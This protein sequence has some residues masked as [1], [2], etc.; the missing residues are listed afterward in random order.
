[1]GSIA[2]NAIAVALATSV[3]VNVEFPIEIFIELL[4]VGGFGSTGCS[5]IGGPE[6]SWPKAPSCGL[7]DV[8]IKRDKIVIRSFKICKN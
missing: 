7:H 2:L 8:K 6:T 5:G 3:A 4:S 1:M